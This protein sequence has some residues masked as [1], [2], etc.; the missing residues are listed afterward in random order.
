[1]RL[2]H[3]P[4]KLRIAKDFDRILKKQTKKNKTKKDVRNYFSEWLK[5]GFAENLRLSAGFWVRNNHLSPLCV[6]FLFFFLDVGNLSYFLTL[7]N[8][9]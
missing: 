4:Q 3:T 9:T 6:F 1:M 7:L 2:L 8:L 5:I